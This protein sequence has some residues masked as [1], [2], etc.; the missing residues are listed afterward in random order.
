MDQTRVRHWRGS[1]VG[2]PLGSA[3]ITTG[4]QSSGSAVVTV[5]VVTG[6]WLDELKRGERYF[7][8]FELC[9][10]SDMVLIYEV[11]VVNTIARKDMTPGRLSE[12]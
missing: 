9:C 12:P 1:T 6:L 5:I 11:V 7:A 2:E 4:V 10:F 8:F 3:A